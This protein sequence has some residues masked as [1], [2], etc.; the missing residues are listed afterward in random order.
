MGS[1]K[2]LY[3]L[4]ELILDITQASQWIGQRSDLHDIPYY[5]S[6]PLNK[7]VTFRALLQNYRSKIGGPMLRDLFER[8]LDCVKYSLG[9]SR[10]IGSDIR[11]DVRQIFGDD[12]CVALD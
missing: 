2:G 8:L 12:R 4:E 9:S 3:E 10:I 7:T 1:P 5:E 6:F 11:V